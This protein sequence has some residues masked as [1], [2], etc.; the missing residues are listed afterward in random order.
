MFV[1]VSNRFITWSPTFF[2]LLGNPKDS[3]CKRIIMD[4]KYNSSIYDTQTSNRGR[5]LI[6]FKEYNL[7]K[8]YHMMSQLLTKLGY[9]DFLSKVM[10]RWNRYFSLLVFDICIN[11]I[12]Y[13]T[14]ELLMNVRFKQHIL[15]SDTR[16]MLWSYS[17]GK[18]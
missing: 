4:V 11:Y 2:E 13:I 5:N 12:F 18:T 6:T 16:S 14:W 10:N 7:Y 8:F 15:C 1:I 3:F 17:P 9:R